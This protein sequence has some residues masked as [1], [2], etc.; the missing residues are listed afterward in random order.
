VLEY[1][2][3][4]NADLEKD[5]GF[6]VP[7]ISAA[8]ASTGQT[9]VRLWTGMGFHPE[10]VSGPWEVLGP[11]ASGELTGI[12]D[13]ALRSD[14]VGA[15]LKIRLEKWKPDSLWGLAIE[16]AWFQVSL[17]PG[18]VQQYRMRYRLGQVNG[19][20]VQLE[21]PGPIANSNLRVVIDG[22]TISWQPGT[23][24][25]DASNSD[26]RIQVPLPFKIG[27]GFTVLEIRYQMS[28]PKS[29]IS[30]FQ[31]VL[32]PTTISGASTSFP[33]CWQVNF[34]ETWVGLDWQSNSYERQKWNFLG[35]LLT[36]RPVTQEADLEQWFSGQFTGGDAE[37]AQG[38]SY[39]ISW[40]SN[41]DS[42]RIMSLP[43]QLWMIVCSLAFLLVALGVY[44]FA[45]TS[46][47]LWLGLALIAFLVGTLVTLWPGIMIQVI[48][49]CE[50]AVLVL[51]VILAAKYWLFRRYRRQVVFLPGFTRRKTPSSLARQP[52][53]V[54][55]PAGESAILEQP[56]ATAS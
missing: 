35:G 1:F 38:P 19:G 31:S 12:P 13:L 30:A 16:R 4:L 10:W 23:A 21:L 15:S 41:A 27:G 49:G 22:K 11:E 20:K 52:S 47:G 46:R 42:L 51:I 5:G 39:V 50:P 37:F 43:R 28:P 56:K 29:G 53:S 6:S 2:S 25:E 33:T 26:R 34:P 7:L 8:D 24:N 18:G 36:P 9:H 54:S 14:R 40:Q 17:L 55:R 48:Y 3:A 44:F 45:R 32:Q